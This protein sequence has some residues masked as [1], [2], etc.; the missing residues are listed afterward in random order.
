MTEMRKI[1]CFGCSGGYPR[2]CFVQP[3]G[4]RYVHMAGSTNSHG[5]HL[6]LSIVCTIDKSFFSQEIEEAIFETC[7]QQIGKPP[8]TKLHTS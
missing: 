1:Y 7:L 6:S 2:T 5:L 3:N 4:N 8:E